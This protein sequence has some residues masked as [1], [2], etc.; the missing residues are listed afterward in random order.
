MDP[1]SGP[2]RTPNRVP[3]RV[4]TDPK[5]GPPGPKRVPRGSKSGPKGGP[6]GPAAGPEISGKFP[7]NFGVGAGPGLAGPENTRKNPENTRKSAKIGGKSPIFGVIFE[8]FPIFPKFGRIFGFL[9]GPETI[10]FEKTRKSR[11]WPPPISEIRPSQPIFR[12]FRKSCPQR[13]G[14]TQP[15]LHGGWGTRGVQNGLWALG[16]DLGKI[17]KFRDFQARKPPKTRGRMEKQKLEN[18]DPP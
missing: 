15:L 7:E 8:N 9:G 3:N 2:K 6:P 13:P 12:F 11:F 10:F 16:E 18:K 17:E 14:L 1:K 4:P 5:S